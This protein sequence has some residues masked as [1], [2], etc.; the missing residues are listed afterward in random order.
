MDLRSVICYQDGDP[1]KRAGATPELVFEKGGVEGWYQ[2]VETM[3][4]KRT[5]RSQT[6]G[7][8]T[9][10]STT[11]VLGIAGGGI[12][13]IVLVVIVLV[14]WW[15][16]PRRY[17]QKQPISIPIAGKLVSGTVKVTIDA[18]RGILGSAGKAFL[19]FFD[20]KGISRM[21]AGDAKAGASV[22]GQLLKLVI[23]VL[24]FLAALAAFG[25]IG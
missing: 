16:W 9:T 14:V 18:T 23:I 25:R 6:T 2:Y 8:T 12:G 17:E 20:G 7:T 21:P 5:P 4:C 11:V 24:L 22:V 15:T 1:D 13:L 3:G 10:S 19:P